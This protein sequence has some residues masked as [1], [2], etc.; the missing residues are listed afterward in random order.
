MAILNISILVAVGA[1]DKVMVLSIWGVGLKTFALV[2]LTPLF[3]IIGAAWAINITQ[4][5]TCLAS[6]YEV[7][8]F[9][10][11]PGASVPPK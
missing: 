9:L 11:Q 2:V 10:P 5:F 8:R 3:G 1:T 7:K 4:I 6:L